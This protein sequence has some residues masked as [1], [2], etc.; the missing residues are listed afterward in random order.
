M[1]NPSPIPAVPEIIQPAGD[2][3][4]YHSLCWGAVLAGTVA[5]IGIHLLLTALGVGAG[6][7]TF[8]PMTDLNPVA[9]FSV[10]AGIVWSVC[11]IVA[12]WF[13][14]LVAGR[15]SGCPHRGF[16]HGILVWSLTLILT[17]LLLS[18]GTGL[19]LGGALKVL[20]GGLGIGGNAVA[21]SA[22]DLASAGVQRSRAE[23][24]SF[25]AEAVQ[26]IP[27]NAAP[28]TSTR[29]QREVG[30]A[31]AKLFAPENEATFQDNRMAAINALMRFTQMSEAEATITINNWIG[32]YKDL[33]AELNN[34]KAG[35]EQKA[36]ATAD[37]AAHNLS[38]A[39]IWSFFALL[40]GLLAA[41]LG[42]R[43]GARWALR[44]ANML[45]SPAPC[46]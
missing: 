45:R 13:G 25:V 1:T 4:Y 31:V 20:G 34:L 29:A 43:C 23:L 39:A 46:Q 38:C 33:Q 28:M 44:H 18:M 17:L 11:A 5:A 26:S 35:T 41:A 24:G 27:T 36:R 21:S 37:Q 2:P 9:N 15:F 12:L 40:I 16:A 6:L 14:G 7:A 8:T 19:V 10:G 3:P 30:F 42:G 32:S 22:G